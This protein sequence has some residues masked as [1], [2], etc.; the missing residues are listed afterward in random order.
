[1]NLSL[2]E[3]VRRLTELEAW[4]PVA[5]SQGLEAAAVTLEHAARA[6]AVDSAAAAAHTRG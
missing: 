2:T 6:K 1:M 4:V 5:L 3:M